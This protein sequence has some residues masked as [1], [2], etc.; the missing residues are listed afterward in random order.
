MHAK[1][2]VSET[3]TKILTEKE[4]MNKKPCSSAV[5]FSLSLSPF[6]LS[7]SLSLSLFYELRHC[8]P[9]DFSRRPPTESD[10]RAQNPCL[11]SLPSARITF[12][13]G[14]M[15]SRSTVKSDFCSFFAAIC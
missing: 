5:C 13:D 9:I 8:F 15:R 7:F 10:L 3:P 1:V 12:E 4:S 6:S 11:R 2:Y 14:L